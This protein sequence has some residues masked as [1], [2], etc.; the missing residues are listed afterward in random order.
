MNSDLTVPAPTSTDRPRELHPTGPYASVICDVLSLGLRPERYQQNPVKIVPKVA[1]V[2]RTHEM[3]SDGTP[4]ELSVEYTKSVGEKAGLRR[5]LEALLGAP[6]PPDA[7][8]DLNKLFNKAALVSII[9][10]TTVQSGKTSARIGTV[11]PLP[12]GMMAP[13]VIDYTRSPYWDTRIAQYASECADYERTKQ[14]PE[15]G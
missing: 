7:P 4:F 8:F 2:F 5:F 11:M 13:V 3:R 12:K 15:R 14:L 9:H 6:L 10:K 1:L